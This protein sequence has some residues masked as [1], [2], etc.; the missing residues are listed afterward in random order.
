MPNTTQTHAARATPQANRAIALA[1]MVQSVSIVE[2]I[3]RTG[4]CDTDDFN[5]IIQSLFAE[6]SKDVADIYG[7]LNQLRTGLHISQKLLGGS[8]LE[9]AKPV[10]TYAA[11][12][13]TLEKKLAKNRGMLAAIGDGMVRIKKQSEYFGRVTHE[14]VIG[15]IADLYGSTISTLKPSIIVRGKPDHLKQ[16]ANTNRIRALLLAGIRAAHLWHKYGGGHLRLLIGRKNLCRETERL[17][18]LASKV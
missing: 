10:M 3:A 5:T 4:L 2:Q 14:S 16:S 15:G 9:Q 1:A 8:Q 13:I 7:D 11:G 6:N 12:L 17:I 18:R